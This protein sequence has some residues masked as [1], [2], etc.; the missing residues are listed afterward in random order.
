MKLINLKKLDL[1]FKIN[2][3]KEAEVFAQLSKSFKMLKK[4]KKLTLWFEYP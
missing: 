3:K 1:M 4:L 2:T